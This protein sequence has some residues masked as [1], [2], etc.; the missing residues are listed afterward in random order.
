MH[1][2]CRKREF[3]AANTSCREATEAWCE[4]SLRASRRTPKRNGASLAADPTL[5]GVWFPPKREALRLAFQCRSEEWPI[6]ARRSRRRRFRRWLGL[7]AR[8]SPVAW[9]FRDRSFDP[10]LKR[11]R[12][13]RRLCR[14]SA[15]GRKFRPFR[16]CALAA[17]T[18]RDPDRSR[19]NPVTRLVSSLGR[20]AFAVASIRFRNPLS[21]AGLSAFVSKGPIPVSMS[22]RCVAGAIRA[23]ANRP[24]YPLSA[25]LPVDKGG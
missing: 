23:T 13:A 7:A 24:T 2:Q 11:F 17:S 19:T 12:I 25:V 14:T 1:W 21:D 20:A 3:W 10:S 5:T 6:I 22:G 16:L 18:V 4:K 15:P 8:T 9:R